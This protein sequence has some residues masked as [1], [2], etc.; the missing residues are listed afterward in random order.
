MSDWPKEAYWNVVSDIPYTAPISKNC[1]PV[2]V[3]P[4]AQAPEPIGYIAPEDVDRLRMDKWSVAELSSYEAV[5]GNV[6]LYLAPP[7]DHSEDTLDM[8]IRADERERCAKFLEKMSDLWAPS[9]LLEM[10]KR[11]REMGPC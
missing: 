5:G 1:I 2:L 7:T 6:P 11:I 10:A 9:T 3:Y 4:A 8:V